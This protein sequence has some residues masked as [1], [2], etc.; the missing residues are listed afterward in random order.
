MIKPKTSIRHSNILFLVLPGAL[1]LLVVVLSWIANSQLYKHYETLKLAN[2]VMMN[3]QTVISHVTEGETAQRG[4]LITGKVRYLDPFKNFV[5]HKDADFQETVKLVHDDPVMLVEL[6]QL[7]PLIDERAQLLQ[8]IIDLRHTHDLSYI[9]KLPSLDRQKELQDQMSALVFRMDAQE[10]EKIN[11][12]NHE[13]MI[14][15]QISRSALALVLLV[16]IGL[17]IFLVI[18]DRRQKIK[19][20]EAEAVIKESA[21]DKERLQIEL[22]QNL[23][24]LTRMGEVA[25]VGAWEIDLATQQIVWSSEVF[26]I[27]EIDNATIPTLKESLHFFTPE[28]RTQIIEA[29]KNTRAQGTRWDLQL[30]V[31]T[32]KGNR[33][34]VRVIGQAMMQSGVA[35][36]L[37]GAIQDITERRQAEVSLHIANEALMLERDRA[38]AANRAKSQFLANMSHEIRTPMNAV[39]GMIQLLGQTELTLRQHDY[40]HKTQQSAKSLLMI[41]NDILDFSKIEAGKLSL[42]TQSFSLDKMMRDM[43]VILSSSLDKKDIEALIDVDS[44]LPAEIKGDSLRLQQVLI[45]L[46]GNAVKFTECGEIILSLR[47]VKSTLSQ[48]SIEFSVSDTGIGISKENVERIFEGFSQAEAS[49]TRRFGGTGLGLAISKQLVAAMGGELQLDSTLGLGSRF[50]FTLPFDPVTNIQSISNKYP[51]TLTPGLTSGHKLRA[52]VVD[53]NPMAREVLESMVQALGWQCDSASSGRDAV[54]IMQR[55]IDHDHAYDVVF[56]DWEMPEMNG[57]QTAQQ[58]RKSQI[59]SATPI[60]IMV[61]AHGREALA[62]I[63]LD[64]QTT[65]DGFLVKPFTKSM[66]YDAVVDA[67]SGTTQDVVTKRPTENRLLG[68]R[69]LLVEDNL[70]NQQ[71]ARELLEHEGAQVTVASNGRLA[72]DVA[73]KGDQRFDAILMDI[74]MPDMDGFTAAALIRKDVRLQS[75]PIIAMTANVMASDREACLQA[76]MNDHISKPIDLETMVS[77]ILNHC[78]KIPVISTLLPHEAELDES[79]S[80]IDPNTGFQLALKRINGDQKLFKY[81]AKMFVQ[82]VATTSQELDQHIHRDEKDEAAR[83]IHTLKGIASTIG[84]DSLVKLVVSM[85]KQLKKTDNL[86]GLAPLTH[87]LNLLIQTSCNELMAYCELLQGTTKSPINTATSEQMIDLDKQALQAQLEQLQALMTDKNMRAM[88]VFSQ[89]KTTFGVALG[90]QLIPLENAINQLDFPLALEKIQYLQKNIKAF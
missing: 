50:F 14:A 3:L 8:N 64:E 22:R 5:A 30:Q 17:W 66:L 72:V 25:K 47:L 38:D 31:I 82:T 75:L 84:A 20:L 61:S 23:Y 28:S 88:T 80:K 71:V 42:D 68:L 65:L 4:Y 9:L 41:L 32:A 56:M 73:L 85:E 37:E 1:A 87:Q 70:I 54:A 67:Q 55:G 33:I 27:N 34:W 21:F 29:E 63:L 89:L 44:S 83:L 53:D 18:S 90:D 79:H 58:I 69:L 26:R 35:I 12:S 15:T 74:Q 39:L 11:R 7:K 24:R 62:E 51:I 46:I 78:G 6:R 48:I 59:Q 81:I 77:T 52:L 36:K 76:G 2:N 10:K 86:A 19:N 16:I 13:V 57:L 43:A 60:I 49:T 40:V 45:N